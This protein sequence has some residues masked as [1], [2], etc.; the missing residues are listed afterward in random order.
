MRGFL[1]NGFT[2]AGN[3]SLILFAQTVSSTAGL[4]MGKGLNV[5]STASNALVAMEN[6]LHASHI[7]GDSVAMQLCEEGYDGDH[8]FGFMATSNTSFTPVQQALRSW[9]NATCLTLKSTQQVTSTASFTRR[10]WCWRPTRR[11]TGLRPTRPPRSGTRC[12]AAAWSAA[13]TA[14]RSRWYRVTAARRWRPSAASRRP[15]ASR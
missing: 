11:S 7:T 2:A 5:P 10:R 12:A 14:P 3:G 1:A 13:A 15:T 6:A 8:V 9:A 4:Y